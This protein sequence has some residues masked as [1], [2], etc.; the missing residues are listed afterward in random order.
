MPTAA[1]PATDEARLLWLEAVQRMLGRAAHDVRDGLNGVS[2]NL[3]VIRSR[4]ARPAV[5]ASAVAPFAEAATQQLDRLTSLLEAVLALGRVEREPADVVAVLRHLATVCSA[6]SVQG[7]AAVEVVDEAGKADVGTSTSVPGDLVRLALAAP[8]L[9][10]VTRRASASGDLAVRCA[11]TPAA[12]G[13]TVTIT[14][15][16]ALPMPAAVADAVRAGGVSWTEGPEHLSLAFP[17]A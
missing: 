5:A 9:E 11:V 4:S 15:G 3:E 12:A 6:S 10:A 13:V 14:A 1:A 16:R 8:L 2:V 17:R 7:D